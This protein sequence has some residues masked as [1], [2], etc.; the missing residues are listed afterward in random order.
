MLRSLVGDIPRYG[1]L[2]VHESISLAPMLGFMVLRSSTIHQA[3]EV[4]PTQKWLFKIHVEE[5]I[6]F[7]LN[8]PTV[9][10]CHSRTQNWPQLHILSKK[11]HTKQPQGIVG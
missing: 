4:P 5:G 7:T 9:T 8:S 2:A 11:N 3:A 1:H 6:A 10:T